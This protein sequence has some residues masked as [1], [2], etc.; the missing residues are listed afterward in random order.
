MICIY[1]HIYF[2]LPPFS[3]LSSLPIV[4]YLFISNKKKGF[5]I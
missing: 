1:T 2:S 5:I 4:S 3:P